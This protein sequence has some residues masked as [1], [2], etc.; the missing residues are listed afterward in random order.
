MLN[1][2]TVYADKPRGWIHLA[3]IRADPHHATASAN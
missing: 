1:I 2:P 3:T